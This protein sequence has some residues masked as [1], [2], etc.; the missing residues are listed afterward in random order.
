MVGLAPGPMARRLTPDL[1]AVLRLLGRLDRDRILGFRS[2]G[3]AA[4]IRCDYDRAA[5]GVE[6]SGGHVSLLLELDRRGRVVP[7]GAADDQRPR[8]RIVAERVQLLTSQ[9][10]KVFLL[11]RLRPGA[12]SLGPLA[13]G[14]RLDDQ[15]H[16]QPALVAALDAELAAEVAELA[17]VAAADLKPP[18]NP[19]LP[20]L[21]VPPGC[22]TVRPGAAARLSTELLP[23]RRTGRHRTGRPERSAEALEVLGSEQPGRRSPELCSGTARFWNSVCWFT[24]LG[25]GITRSATG[26]TRVTFSSSRR[27]KVVIS[28]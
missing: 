9:V 6:W 25:I 13:P 26:N 16:Q 28:M 23:S 11:A 5:A 18:P 7:R 20:S 21:R 10:G 14:D 19:W 4:A 1:A 27:S 15:V 22:R 2:R 24:E 8:R 12:R 17:E 3:A